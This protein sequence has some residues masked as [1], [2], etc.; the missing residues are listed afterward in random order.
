MTNIYD[1]TIILG[2]GSIVFGGNTYTSND[3]IIK[4]VKEIKSCIQHTRVT[5]LNIT[6]ITVAYDTTRLTG[7]SGVLYNGIVYTSNKVFTEIDS[8]TTPCTHNISV[9]IIN[10]LP[11]NIVRDTVTYVGCG[12]V[13]FNG[14]VYTTSTILSQTNTQT[15]SCTQLI[16]TTIITI[17]NYTIVQDTTTIRGCGSVTHNGIVYTQS[18]TLNISFIRQD[19]C[20][21]R[22]S[23]TFIIVNPITI[24]NDTIRVSG[25]DSL[26]FE[27]VNYMITDTLRSSITNNNFCSQANRI[28]HLPLIITYRLWTMDNG[29]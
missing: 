8:T 14:N 12:S 1:T 26:V 16:H 20:T 28:V 29:L 7:C 4:V 23:T 6:P 5:I 9:V 17:N 11:L 2:C 25:C 15:E 13:T 24:T 3:T 18:D 27:G 19:S 22:N 21:K 10:V